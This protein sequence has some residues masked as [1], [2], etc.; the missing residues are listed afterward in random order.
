MLNVRQTFGLRETKGDFGVEIEVEGHNLP[1]PVKYWRREHDGSLRGMEN[2]EY[3]LAK[4]LGAKALSNALRYLDEAYQDSGSV[5]DESVRAGVHVHINVQELNMVEVYNMI[6]IYLILEELMVKYCGCHREGNLFCLRAV[7]AEY[8][9]YF[10]AEVAQTRNYQ[11][12][13]N[14]MVRY[15]SLNVKA[16]PQYGSLEFRA[17]R[18]TRDLELVETWAHMLL[19]LRDAAKTYF[20]PQDIIN[21]FSGGG[22]EA[23][24]DKCLGEY[25]P[26]FKAFDGWR[27]ILK[28]GIRQAQEVAFATNWNDFKEWEDKRDVGRNNPDGQPQQFKHGRMFNIHDPKMVEAIKRYEERMR[29][30]AEAGEPVPHPWKRE[31]V[32]FDIAPPVPGLEEHL[33]KFPE[34]V[35]GD[36]EEVDD[37]DGD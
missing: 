28:R 13:G 8:L 4:P 25:A 24:L 5:V 18:G 37:W 12:F 1:W 33:I 2:A 20:D 10:L 15:A 34:E 29:R 30:Q 36:D 6:V 7:D 17:M 21:G 11:N 32:A 9:P 23:F 16:L 19:G 31:G 26:I 14:D 22:E 3:V 27:L 35:G